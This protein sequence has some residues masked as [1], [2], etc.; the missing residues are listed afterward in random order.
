MWS[1]D[2]M[3]KIIILG[4]DHSAGEALRSLEEMGM[5][6]PSQVE[7]QPLPCGGSLDVLHI[8]HALEAGAERI[9]V[10]SCFDG[11]CHSLQGNKW[12]EKRV[13]TAQALLEEAGWPDNRV[14]YRQI[15]P[16]MASDLNRWITELEILSETRTPS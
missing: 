9:L 8:L 4:C 12:A 16:S 2:K 7:F 1:K 15:S 5:C 3:A 11:A 6:L 13:S 14:T 10:L